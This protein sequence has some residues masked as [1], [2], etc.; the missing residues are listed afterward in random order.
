LKTN[1]NPAQSGKFFSGNRLKR[2]A[3]EQV[4][5]QR[6]GALLWARLE[7]IGVKTV[8]GFSLL[9]DDPLTALAD[10]VPKMDAT[11][12]LKL[13][14]SARAF[15]TEQAAAGTS[16]KKRKKLAAPLPA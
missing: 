15:L 3:R 14:D 11:E 8:R 1:E 9:A 10:Q 13:R 7:T 2:R 5:T 6:M 12:L 4:F 16:D